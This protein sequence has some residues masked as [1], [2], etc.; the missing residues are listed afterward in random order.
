MMADGMHFGLWLVAIIMHF[1]AFCSF[2]RQLV[3]LADRSAVHSSQLRPP[4]LR[5]EVLP[6]VA[7]GL[8]I[9]LSPDVLRPSLADH[10]SIAGV[11][12]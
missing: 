6:G 8:P 10:S 2:F 9:T 3:Q 7:G 4:N 11:T 5:R 1:Q 12:A